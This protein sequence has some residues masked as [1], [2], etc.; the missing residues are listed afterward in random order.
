MIALL[1]VNVLVALFLARHIHHELAHDWFDDQAS[2]GWATSPLTENGFLRVMCQPSATAMPHRPA[3]V[4]KMLR[5]L[6]AGSHHRFWEDSVSLRDEQVFNPSL[7]RGHK[8]VTDIYLLG[9]ATTRRGRFATFDRGV[10]L[11]AVRGATKAN[12]QV[13]SAAPGE[14][15]SGDR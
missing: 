2:Q 3:D 15:T 13:I 8:Q 11:G 14:S 4:A 5:T 7:I 6:C 1:D 12:L 10:Q 9:L